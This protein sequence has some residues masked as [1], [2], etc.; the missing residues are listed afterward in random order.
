MS[1]AGSH[2]TWCLQIKRKSRTQ[3]F[4]YF[5]GDISY[6]R[7][8]GTL[9]KLGQTAPTF[10]HLNQSEIF[11]CWSWR[12]KL[13]NTLTDSSPFN[14]RRSAAPPSSLSHRW[15]RLTR[16]AI[17]KPGLWPS[18]KLLSGDKSILQSRADGHLAHCNRS[19]SLDSLWRSLPTDVE[20]RQTCWLTRTAGRIKQGSSS[21]PTI[22]ESSP[23]AFCQ[24]TITP[25][26]Q[27]K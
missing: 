22:R 12:L 10:L 9:S 25:L 19:L 1:P 18:S 16:T 5:F 3:S 27:P 13:E 2:F 23:P 6:L 4:Y 8:S 21:H 7:C 17:I 14:A 24:N 20:P 26:V 15:H 11:W